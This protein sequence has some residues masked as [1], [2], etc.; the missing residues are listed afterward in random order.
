MRGRIA[1]LLAGGLAIAGCGAERPEDSAADDADGDGAASGLCVTYYAD[2]NEVSSRGRLV[3]LDVTF[4]YTASRSGSTNAGDASMTLDARSRL[5]GRSS[6]L[7]C[8][9]DTGHGGVRYELRRR[10]DDE[11]PFASTHAGTAQLAGSRVMQANGM[12]SHEEVDVTGTLER[13]RVVDLGPWEGPRT[14]TCAIL[15]FDVPLRG[16]SIR[17]ISAPGV[18]REEEMNP[19]DLVLDGYSALSPTTYSGGDH[20]FLEQSFPICTAQESTARGDYG[21]PGGM[22]ISEDGLVWQRSG[23][24]RQHAGGP[25]EQRTVEFTLRVVPPTLHQQ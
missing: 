17:R 7:A 22:T 24:W 20:R 8:A 19:S 14:D 15:A 9:W 11:P 5:E 21:P 10:G 18:Q 12:T 16:K 13:L 6:Q 23:P 4:A 1:W 3:Q 25:R 2:S